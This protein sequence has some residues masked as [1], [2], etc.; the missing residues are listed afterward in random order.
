MTAPY[1]LEDLR[2]RRAE[3]EEIAAKRGIRNV[4]VF[5]SVASGEQEEGSD[6]DLLVDVAPDQSPTVIFSFTVDMRDALGCPVDVLTFVPGHPYYDQPD[7][8]PMV[9]RINREA[10]PL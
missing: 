9:D 1:T 3:I 6:V 2:A 5:G 10:V 4:R 8:K 7:V